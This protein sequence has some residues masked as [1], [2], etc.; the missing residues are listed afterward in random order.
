MK[1]KFG[2][3]SQEFD[4]SGEASYT[5]V[6][7]INDEE[8]RYP[9]YLEADKITLSNSELEK[10]ALQKV[11]EDN[12]PNKATDDR[13]KAIQ[14]QTEKAQAEYAEVQKSL[15]DLKEK[16]AAEEA[17]RKR[18]I[19]NK[20]AF[21]KALADSMTEITAQQGVI[22]QANK[23]EADLTATQIKEANSAILKASFQTAQLLSDVIEIF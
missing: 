6:I 22:R 10:L 17:A 2:T 15:K 1:L 8:A 7:L 19:E 3:K 5:K 14:E 21:L 20:A 12:F 9:V 16:S 18:I 11:Y 23:D 4:A 13:F